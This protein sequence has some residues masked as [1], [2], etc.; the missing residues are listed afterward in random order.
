MA[1]L[2][3][4]FVTIYLALLSAHVTT[5]MARGNYEHTTPFP[6]FASFFRMLLTF[7]AV[8]SGFWAFDWYLPILAFV[9]GGLLVGVTLARNN[10]LLGWLFRAQAVLDVLIVAALCFLISTIWFV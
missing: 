7:A 2:V 4:Y 3:V 8:I 1:F 10:E 9:G 5:V 6:I